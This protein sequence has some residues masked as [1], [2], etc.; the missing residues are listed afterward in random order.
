MIQ[1]L[2]DAIKITLADATKEFSAA[3]ILDWPIPSSSSLPKL[4][5]IAIYPGKLTFNRNDRELSEG[6]PRLHQ[7]RQTIAVDPSQSDK[8]YAL[9]NKPLEGTVKAHLIADTGTEDGRRRSPIEAGDF[10]LGDN[11]RT[12]K[13]K[14]Q[15]KFPGKVYLDY[16]YLGAM[17]IKEFQQELIFDF[18]DADIAGVEKLNALATGIVL[19][20]YNGLIETGNEE[21]KSRFPCDPVSVIPR[22]EGMAILDAIPDIQ[23]NL[24]RLQLKLQVS[25]TL[26]I[27]REIAD[28]SDVIKSIA[29][30]G[31]DPGKGIGIR[32]QENHDSEGT[33]VYDRKKKTKATR[34]KS[35]AATK[36]KRSESKRK[37]P[38][39]NKEQN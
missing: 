18:C 5:V 16:A 9:D 35:N 1:S 36:S 13:F 17:T 29:A 8:Q 39:K 15:F 14:K 2:I 19:T 23:E 30:P 6:L 21:A 27:V 31:T 4:P 33:Q 26:R 28:D 25:G 12:I 22:I 32:I 37:T 7:T 11:H 20:D 24:R 3:D 34:I 10:T 38:K